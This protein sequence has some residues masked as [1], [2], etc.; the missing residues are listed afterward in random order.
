MEI[1]FLVSNKILIFTL[2]K[3]VKQLANDKYNKTV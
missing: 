2:Y 3:P 1:N